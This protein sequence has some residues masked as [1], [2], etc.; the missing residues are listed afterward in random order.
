MPI[1]SI[2][3]CSNTLYTSNMDMR[4]SQRWFTASTIT[5]KCHV[6]SALPQF[7]NIWPHRYRYNSVRMHP[8][9][10]PQHMKVLKHFIY[11]QYGCGMQTAV[12]YSIN[13]DTTMS[14]GL[15]LTPISKKI[16]PTCT[17]ITITVQGC[18]NMLIHRTWK[19]SN[20][21]YTSNMDVGCS[22]RWFAASTMTPQRHLGSAIPQY[23]EIWHPP[24][25]V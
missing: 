1:H 2:W 16:A 9:S 10:H 5:P 17:G 15:R 8:Y 6:C 23:S 18:T 25:R 4:C 24:A 11:I 19:W 3:W 7:S 14:F 22:Q 20:N 21:L 12:I 13:H